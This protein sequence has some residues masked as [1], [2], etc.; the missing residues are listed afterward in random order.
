MQ[1]FAMAPVGR[2]T[3]WWLIIVVVAVVLAGALILVLAQTPKF[4]V[5]PEGLHISG[6]PFGRTIPAADLRLDGAH[7]VDFATSP[8]LR[9]KWRTMGL[10][11]PGF[12]AGWFR[13]YDGE[14]ALV[15]LSDAKPALYIPTTAGY[16][17]LISPQDPDGLLASLRAI[18]H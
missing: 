6:N 2:K 1:V 3:M 8:D 5:S 7:V 14:T 18:A 17:L 10:G 9:P 12:K 15:F 4:E 11:L 13:L 16:S